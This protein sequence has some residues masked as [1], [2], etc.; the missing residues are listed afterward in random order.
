M[1]EDTPDFMQTALQLRGFCPSTMVD[2]NQLLLPGNPALGVVCFNGLNYSFATEDALLAFMADPVK[3]N[4]GVLEAARLNPELI[5]LLRIQQHFH[6]YFNAGEGGDFSSGA[7]TMLAPSG[8]AMV[9]S[10]CQTPTH[11]VE[12]YV[13]PKYLWNEWDLRRQ[14][15]QL[16]NLRNM[17]TVSTQTRLSNLRRENE[18]QVYLPRN[19]TTNTSISTGTNVARSVNYI[20][21]LRCEHRGQMPQDP[22][23]MKQHIQKLRDGEAPGTKIQVVNLTFELS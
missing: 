5:H 7:A 22:E 1:P 19:K 13:D 9:D 10:D 4:A 15:L 23:S 20:K 18:T 17:T 21:G 8:P 12:K 14:A 16:A 3:Y 2:R 6:P 11:F